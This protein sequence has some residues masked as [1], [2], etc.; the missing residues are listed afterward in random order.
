MPSKLERSTRLNRRAQAD[1]TARSGRR[2]FLNALAGAACAA[3]FLRPSTVLGSDLRIGQLAPEAVLATLD[4]KRISSRDLMGQVVILCFWATWCAP[5]REELPMLSRA[6]TQ[7]AR[8]GLTVLGFSMDTP[9][10][11]SAVRS[12]A[13]QL[14]FPVGLMAQSSAP[15]YGRIWRLPVNFIIDRQ[16]RLIMNGWKEKSSGLTEQR[17]REVLQTA[18]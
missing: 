16:G 6:A 18:L 14:K 15:G 17:L 9:D 1:G 13:A 10:L 12:T 5:C 2:A 11:M 4:G 3:A 7:H 8:D